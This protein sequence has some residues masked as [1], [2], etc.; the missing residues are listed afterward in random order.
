MFFVPIFLFGFL[1]NRYKLDA[2]TSYFRAAVTVVLYTDQ[3]WIRDAI[4]YTATGVKTNF[5]EP[6][7]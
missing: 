6:F 1:G 7:T 5:I 3:I 2:G 4:L